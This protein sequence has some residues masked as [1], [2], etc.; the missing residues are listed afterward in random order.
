MNGRLGKPRRHRRERRLALMRGPSRGCLPDVLQAGP[1]LPPED[2]GRRQ[3]A[4]RRVMTILG[5]GWGHAEMP[6]VTAS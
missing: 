6:G 2:V 1:S 5:I 4:G 3:R